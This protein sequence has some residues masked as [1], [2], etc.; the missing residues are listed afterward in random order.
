MKHGL[1]V[2]QIFTKMVTRPHRAG[3]FLSSVTAGWKDSR[4]NNML[5]RIDLEQASRDR[6]DCLGR[7]FGG[8]ERVEEFLAELRSDHEFQEIQAQRRLQIRELIRN[9][10]A[11]VGTSSPFDAETLYVITR[12]LQP[13]IIVETGVQY[14][15]HTAHILLALKN[16]GR[17]QLH[18]ID[19]PQ[20]LSPLECGYLVPEDLRGR[21]HLL[22]GDARDLLPKLLGQLH[23]IDIFIHDSD[24][25]Y[26]H[27]AW[28]YQTAWPYIVSGGVL[29]SHDV[30]YNSAFRELC[31]R[32]RNEISDSFELF[33]SGVAAKRRETA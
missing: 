11:L 21:W 28:E 24:H 31:Q 26:R 9:R 16:N 27:M 14:G 15:A 17:G 22:L 29:F 12:A 3:A 4:V 8:A 7:L 1:S 33:A 25:S 13:E 6:D 32:H 19:F 30:H 20:D 23:S 5:A 10:R 18:S 2:G